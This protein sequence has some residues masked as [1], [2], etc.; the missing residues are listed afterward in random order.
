MGS[1]P[2]PQNALTRCKKGPGPYLNKC[3]E[4]RGMTSQ[5]EGGRNWHTK[6]RD[7]NFPWG[8]EKATLRNV[9]GEAE[10]EIRKKPS[11]E[12]FPNQVLPHP[13][14]HTKDGKKEGARWAK[15]TEG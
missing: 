13:L 1:T 10:E 9:Q 7:I 12:V 6:P 5:K 11:A 2:Q 3:A 8:G 15:G 14:L 4:K